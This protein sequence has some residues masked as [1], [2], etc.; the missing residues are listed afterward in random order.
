MV[1]IGFF[2]C[3]A[4]SRF[5]LGG[6]YSA[7]GCG[8]AEAELRGEGRSGDVEPQA[9][10]FW[11]LQKE[12]RNPGWAQDGIVDGFFWVP[13]VWQ[14][15][16]KG[17]VLKTLTEREEDKGFQKYGRKEHLNFEHIYCIERERERERETEK[18]ILDCNQHFTKSSCTVLH[19]I[20]G[21]NPRSKE[22]SSSILYSYEHCT[23][24]VE[25]CEG[26]FSR[27]FLMRR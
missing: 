27:T 1:Y 8:E 14:S 5:G 22:L 24:S 21:M 18:Q 10:C 17:E 16:T 7:L 2:A 13:R 19:E 12:P 3:R 15:C 11:S 20:D 4:D 23:L 25:S 26:I 6:V 9:G